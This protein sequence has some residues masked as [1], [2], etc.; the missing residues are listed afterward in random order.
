MLRDNACWNFEIL[1]NTSRWL[2]TAPLYPIIILRD[3][4]RIQLAGL[5]LD[6]D[7]MLYSH[8]NH[9]L[10]ESRY[11]KLYSVSFSFFFFSLSLNLNFVTCSVKVWRSKR[12]AD[13]RWIVFVAVYPK[14]SL[15]SKDSFFLLVGYNGV[16]LFQTWPSPGAIDFLVKVRATGARSCCWSGERGHTHTHTTS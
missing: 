16:L 14:L 8:V 9:V 6:R 10:H 15:Y 2:M 1:R 5:A 12:S 4:T 13:L 3:V 7:C 11:Q